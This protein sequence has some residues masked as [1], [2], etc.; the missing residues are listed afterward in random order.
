MKLRKSGKQRRAEIQ[1]ARLERREARRRPAPAF[2]RS[3]RPP[4]QAPVDPSRLRPCNSYGEPDFVRRGYY[5]DMPFRC[6]D[7]GAE[8]VWTAEQQ[9]WW[10]EEAKGYVYS[11]ARRCRACRARERLRRENARRVHLEGLLRKQASG[12]AD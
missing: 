2:P 1:A 11:T 7:C 8:E 10:Y 12:H 6:I 4:G 3:L 9:R 5:E